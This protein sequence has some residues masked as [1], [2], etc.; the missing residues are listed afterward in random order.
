M[1][2]VERDADEERVRVRATDLD[3]MRRVALVVEELSVD[4]RRSQ[5]REALLQTGED[6]RQGRLHGRLLSPVLVGDMDELVHQLVDERDRE[7]ARS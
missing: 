2:E 1:P 3:P 6:V 5:P 4:I 7:G